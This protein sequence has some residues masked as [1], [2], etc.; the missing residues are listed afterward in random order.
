M[1]LNKYISETGIC[2]R[3]EADQWNEQGRVTLNGVRA[4]LGTQGNDG[5]GVRVNGKL[6]GAK[7]NIVYTVANQPVW[8]TTHTRRHSFVR[9]PVAYA[10][11]T[12]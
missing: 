10:S 12:R 8:L 9:W 4:E 6:L 1:R 7:E 2:S 3:R 11:S 5:D